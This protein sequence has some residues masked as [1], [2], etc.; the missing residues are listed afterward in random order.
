MRLV[1]TKKNGHRGS[2]AGSR[3]FGEVFD[4]PDDLARALLESDPGAFSEAEDSGAATKA[5]EE[6]QRSKPYRG[7]RK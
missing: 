4:L 6:P 1:C 5:L 3:S 2:S 7:K